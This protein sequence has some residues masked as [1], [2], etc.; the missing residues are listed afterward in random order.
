MTHTN[1][2]AQ[3]QEQPR[4]AEIVVVEAGIAFGAWALMTNG[5]RRYFS[6]SRASRYLAVQATEALIKEA[7]AAKA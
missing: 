2:T 3:E 1:L 7:G 4:V 6:G 5:A